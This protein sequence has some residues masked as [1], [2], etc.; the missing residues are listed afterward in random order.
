[1]INAAVFV[2][3]SSF[4]MN[5]LTPLIGQEVAGKVTL[6]HIYEIALV[7][8]KVI[9]III[10]SLILYNIYYYTFFRIISSNT[11]R[12]MISFCL[13]FIDVSFR[14]THSGTHR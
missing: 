1:M 3:L 12:C 13:N 5:I 11:N 2:V 8:S 9:D 7:K 14:T 4:L 6:K 10:A